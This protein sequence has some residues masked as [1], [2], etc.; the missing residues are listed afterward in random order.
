MR[1]GWRPTEGAPPGFFE[2]E[3]GDLVLEAR[4]VYRDAPEKPSRWSIHRGAN[5]IVQEG[6]EPTLAQAMERAE[7]VAEALTR[8]LGGSG[9]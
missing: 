7:I 8:A 5:Q 2:R 6:T 3:V 9:R 1:D 4:L